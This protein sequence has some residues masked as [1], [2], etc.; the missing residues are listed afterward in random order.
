DRRPGGC[1]LAAVVTAVTGGPA[2]SRR[3]SPRTPRRP[4]PPG[5]WNTW[6]STSGGRPGLPGRLFPDGVA[7]PV[8]HPT[9]LRLIPL[10]PRTPDD[11]GSCARAGGGCQDTRP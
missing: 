3:R 9:V 10:R 8:L 11:L 5:A 1:W 7:R 4:A 2:R 6:S